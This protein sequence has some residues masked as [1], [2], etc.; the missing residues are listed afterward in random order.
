MAQEFGS[1]LATP[2]DALQMALEAEQRARDFYEQVFAA[3]ADPDVKLLAAAFA[4][5]EAQHAEW[6]ERALATAPD[7]HVDWQRIF[8]GPSGAG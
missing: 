3:T 5:E 2:H 1:R 4:Q 7:P 6:I 8:A